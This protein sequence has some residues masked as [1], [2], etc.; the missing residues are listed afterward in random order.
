[1]LK[2]NSTYGYPNCPK[3]NSAENVVKNGYARGKRR[4]RCKNCR[5]DFISDINKITRSS[6]FKYTDLRLLSVFLYLMGVKPECIL[7]YII[8]PIK[9]ELSSE[10]IVYQWA[11]KV[12]DGRVGTKVNSKVKIVKIADFRYIES[13]CKDI[14]KTFLNNNARSYM[15][16]ISLNEANPIIC[17]ATNGIRQINEI[18][19]LPFWFR[20]LQ[21]VLFSGIHVRD[22]YTIFKANMPTAT[23]EPC[24]SQNSRNY[25]YIRYCKYEQEIV[26]IKIEQ[27]ILRKRQSR[28]EV[29]TNILICF[30]SNFKAPDI[31]IIDK[32]LYTNKR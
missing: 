30:D 29:G 31:Y 11:A 28:R 22:S 27:E 23:E 6:H 5:Y 18:T 32:T 16:Y 10:K 12:I 1:M 21:Q 8:K 24:S 13:K 2:K 3:C 15:V 25:N 9:P 17:I 14:V 4:W 19:E 20:L 26:Y 7:E